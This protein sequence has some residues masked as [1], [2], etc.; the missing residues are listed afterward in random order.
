MLYIALAGFLSGAVGAMGMGGGGVLLLYLTLFMNVRQR[1]AGGINLMFFI[2]CA[3]IALIL[4]AKEKSI[5]WRK[6]LPLAALG[7]AGSFAGALINGY[8]SEDLLRKMFAFLLLYIGVSELLTKNPKK[9]KTD[10]KT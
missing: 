8:I 2:P 10:K 7:L 6:A 4:H 9:T 3:A 5:I 1:T